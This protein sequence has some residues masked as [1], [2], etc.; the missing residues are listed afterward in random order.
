MLG[1]ADGDLFRATHS[2]CPLRRGDAVLAYTDGATEAADT[3][4]R[5][6]GIAGL[7][8]LLAAPLPPGRSLADSLAAGVARHRAG[9]PADDIL[10]VQVSAAPG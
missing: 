3:A 2:R 5:E 9:P 1:I 6:L 8:A 10:I 7:E 4:G